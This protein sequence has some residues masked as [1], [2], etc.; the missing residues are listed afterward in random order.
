MTQFL[1]A[2]LLMQAWR[3]KRSL[4][5][6]CLVK[7]IHCKGEEKRNELFVGTLMS[8]E[9]SPYTDLWSF[10]SLSQQ[11]LG[12]TLLQHRY[13]NLLSNLYHCWNHWHKELYFNTAIFFSSSDPVSLL[14]HLFFTPTSFFSPHLL[15]HENIFLAGLLFLPGAVGHLVGR[16]DFLITASVVLPSEY[17]SYCQ[18]SYDCMP[19]NCC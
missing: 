7:C 19:P 15:R 1:P 18:V 2:P 6:N 4:K 11:L 10:S 13:Q 16:L 17:S 8:L 5:D 12:T 3:N 14:L 9:M